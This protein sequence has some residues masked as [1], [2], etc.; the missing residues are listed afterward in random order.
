MYIS[1]ALLILLFICKESRCNGEIEGIFREEP[2]STIEDEEILY[3]NLVLEGGGIRGVSYVGAMRSFEEHG[4]YANGR[5]KFVNIT[6]TSVGCL[7]GL[8]VA[9]DI[10]PESMDTLVRS[11]NFHNLFHP[12][13]V[14]L[15]NVPTYETSHYFK[16]LNDLHYYYHWLV[17]ALKVLMIWYENVFTFGVSNDE[18]LMT[19]LETKVLPLSSY[20]IA[21]NNTLADLLNK[22]GH[23]LTCFS[24]RLYNVAMVRINA[25]NNPDATIRETL[26]SSVTLPLVFQPIH[27]SEGYPL[28][29]G[30][31]LNNFP[32]Y[33]YDGRDRRSERTIGLSLNDYPYFAS[34]KSSSSSSSSTS[35]ISHVVSSF[36]NLLYA[37]NKGKSYCNGKCD[38]TRRTNVG[39]E[40][41]HRHH[42]HHHHHHHQHRKF[43]YT[44]VHPH[45]VSSNLQYI[46]SVLD[47]VMNE[48]DRIIYSNDPRNCDRVI[49][50]NS[51]LH[52]LELDASEEKI[53]LA[54]N[55]GYEAVRRFLRYRDRISDACSDDDDSDNYENDNF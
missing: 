7:F 25:R 36:M 55:R 53:S 18:N 10:S 47:I 9:L 22:T 12:N 42:H 21:L 39:E 44:K 51:P 2:S 15:M 3:T 38:S 52:F 50:L 33:E 8:F 1:I 29:D 43:H 40:I 16:L 54:I 17:Y 37:K 32:I 19:W 13:I 49:Y 46:K 31:L 28:V 23:E 41:S 48:R 4:Y 34:R 45:N 26:Y 5:Y 20:D 27:D 6:G 24:T 14:N 11:T 30:G 35:F